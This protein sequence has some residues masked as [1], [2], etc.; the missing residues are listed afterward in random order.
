MAMEGDGCRLLEG[1][2]QA[3][4]WRLNTEENPQLSDH[5]KT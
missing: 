1:I 5:D 3:C 4:A 2:I